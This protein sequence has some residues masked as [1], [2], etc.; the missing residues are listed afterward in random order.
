MFS[1][2]NRNKSLSNQSEIEPN[3]NNEYIEDAK[4]NLYEAILHKRTDIVVS[5]LNQWFKDNQ[6]KHEEIK[7]FFNSNYCQNGTTS[8]LLVAYEQKDCDIMRTLLNFGADPSLIDEKNGKCLF[9]LI[10]DDNS[11]TM[12]QLFSDSFMQAIVQNNVISVK[13]YLK[14][15]FD[16]NNKSVILPDDNSYLHWAC[17]YSIE[18][19]VRLLLDNGSLVNSVNKDGATPLHEAVVRKE[20]KDEVL[21]IIETLLMFKSDPVGIKGSSG[22]FKD[23]SAL[24]LARSRSQ[25]EPEILSLI[26]DF[27][28]DVASVKSHAPLEKVLSEPSPNKTNI[29]HSLDTL[30]NHNDSTVS[31]SSRKST[32]ESDH[33]NNWSQSS[34]TPFIETKEQ[35]PDLKSLIWP[36]PQ[37]CTVLSEDESDRFFL[38][39]VKSQP[40]FIYFKPPYTYT[41]MDLINKLASAFSGI[42]FYCIHKPSDQLPFIYVTI[43][44]NLFQ[45]QSAYSILV[46]KKKIEINAIDSVSLQ[47]AF[48]TFMQLCKIYTRNSIPAL[49]IIDYSDVKYRSVMLDFSQGFYFNYENLLAVL[50]MMAFYKI[51]QVYFYVKFSSLPAM[52]DKKQWYHYM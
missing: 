22:Q 48:F 13:Q 10:N 49:R 44:K 23:M 34:L 52:S 35:K 25:F 1:F 27:L 30:T 14:A 16:V 15:G 20:P 36:Q 32:N 21:K 41:Y 51:N 50:Q 42:T 8:P 11:S 24:D 4:K 12:Q 38:P 28:N 2:L 45:H 19:I 18:P 31:T 43:D 17:M 39:N 5:I 46:T 6:N 26:T 9:S 37:L 7:Y 33:L 40:L 29:M 47:Y 3:Q